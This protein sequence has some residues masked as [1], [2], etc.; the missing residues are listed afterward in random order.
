MRKN[1]LFLVFLLIFSLIAPT[2][3]AASIDSGPIWRPSSPIYEETGI[4]GIYQS[5]LKLPVVASFASL[6]AHP[7][8][9][10]SGLLAYVSRGEY[11]RTANVVSTRGDGGQNAIGPEL[12]QGLGVVRTGELLAARRLDGAE[13]Y[14]T[15]AFDFG[16]SKTLEEAL[17]FWGE[18]I[19]LEDYVRF[20]RTW[21][22][23]VILNHHGSEYETVTGHGQHQATGYIVPKAIELAADPT[24]FPE[25]IEEGLLPWKAQKVY[26][27]GT[28]AGIAQLE[29]DRGQ[30]DPILGRS[31]QEI[32]SESRSYHRTQTMGRLQEIGK[33]ATKFTLKYSA[34]EFAAKEA[35]FFD[36]LDTSIAGIARHIGEEEY[37]VPLLKNDLLAAQQLIEKAITIFD[38]IRPENVVPSLVLALGHFR[39]IKTSVLESRLSDDKQNY[40]VFYLD[41][42]IDELQETIAKATGLKLE[43][44]SSEDV[45]I[46]GETMAATINV[47]N[48]SPLPATLAQVGLIS[49]QTSLA[50][51]AAVGL[52]YNEVFSQKLSFVV[53]E[54]TPTSMVFWR[55]E[56]GTPG[57]QGQLLVNSADIRI[58]NAPFRPYPIV[59]FAEVIVGGQKINL[60]QPAQYRIRDTVTGEFRDPTAVVEPISVSITPGMRALTQKDED[61]IVQFAVRIV[62][63]KAV[64]R[65]ISVELQASELLQVEPK[66][67][68]VH[69]SSKGESQTVEFVV[70]VPA[71]IPNEEYIIQ[72]VVNDNG[73]VYT[74]GYQTIKYPHVERHHLY[75]PARSSIVLFDLEIAPDITI[76]YIMGPGDGI[77]QALAQVGINVVLLDE[78]SL[79]TV[80]LN[81]FDTIVTAPFAYEF[82]KDLVASNKRLLEWVENGGVLIV[83]Y[84]RTPWNNLNVSPYPTRILGDRVTDEHAQ[85]DILVPDHPIF[86]YP[87]KITNQDFEGW[88]QE[89]GLYFLGQWDER[90]VPLLASNDPGEQPQLGG[91]VWTPYGKGGW[92]YNA[93]AFFRQIP[94]GVPGGYRLFS[95]MLSLPAAL[96]QD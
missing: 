56:P 91:L 7:D 4:T 58:V 46:P 72:A 96:N 47:I 42:K 89:R 92:L 66:K 33:S 88:H 75:S 11:A 80:D 15:R 21:R 86:N 22:P 74:D 95:N 14:F 38:P 5:L 18:E 90:Y 70:T 51:E 37:K 82:R 19:I 79:D 30:Y 93:Y 57:S 73:K 76:G 71:G 69:L 6:G 31:Y 29:I 84:N 60:T 25:M 85:I 17:G 65:D 62:N 41:Q 43:V 2:A 40:V 12:Y 61:Q 78:G 27:R 45:Y 64:D 63:N 39:Q 1:R 52:G 44:F 54:N 67:Q 81:K 53:P 28:G 68:I 16:F 77:P 94:G 87:N 23:D 13:Q 50:T 20:I 3:F 55:L 48:R 9:D 36:G 24:A 8:D 10:D 34:V 32:G 59:G 49:G 83:Q 35:S 26:I